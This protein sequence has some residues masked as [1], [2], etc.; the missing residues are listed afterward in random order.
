MGKFTC[1][2]SPPRGGVVFDC[3]SKAS[4]LKDERAFPSRATGRSRRPMMQ[5]GT[6]GAT[7]RY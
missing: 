1:T 3:D 5:N 6:T 4:S 2:T 7:K